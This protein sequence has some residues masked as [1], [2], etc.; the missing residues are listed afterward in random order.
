MYTYKI[1]KKT[2]FTVE[3][4]VAI[5]KDD[6]KKAYE[7]SFSKLQQNLSVEGFR[8]GKIPKSIAE[9]HLAKEEVYKELVNT[10]IP[11]IYEEIVKKEGLKP[12]IQPRIEL[13]KAK[14]N[15]SWEFIISIAEK[16]NIDL[17][18][19]DNVVRKIKSTKKNPEIWI[20]GKDQKKTD[21]SQD[22][23]K[24]QLLNDILD[25]LLKQIK[26]TIPSLIIEIELERRLAQLVDDIRK[27]GLSTD[28]YL[29][30]KSLTMD[31]LKNRFKKEIEDTYKLEF[32]LSDIADKESIKVEQK[33]LDEVFSKIKD[34]KDR[35]E[36][37]NNAYY[38]ASIIR[39]QKTI[40]FILDL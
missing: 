25:G 6:V 24:H 15:D 8:K 5:P 20:P 19:Y 4:V 36:A 23:L 18:G 33:D 28:S 2:D 1:N 34:E 37:Q 32:L 40:D 3:T 9:K 16:P 7:E 12:I 10:L 14:D 31:D 13:T 22:K 17:I 27:I 21:T 11:N 30:S 35:K 29:K 38:Y 26:I 39:K